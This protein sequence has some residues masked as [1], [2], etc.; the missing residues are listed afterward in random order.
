MTSM[1][2][3]VTVFVIALASSMMYFR[4]RSRKKLFG[5]REDANL[6][7]LRTLS[8]TNA[9]L[10]LFEE[11]FRTLAKEL[12]V[13]PGQLRTSDRLADIFEV[14]SWQLGGAQDALEELILKRTIDRPPT[15]DTIQDLLTWLANEQSNTPTECRTTQN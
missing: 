5:T 6:E 11:V 13:L 7:S 14:D 9:P 15:L 3:V 2:P 1:L 4:R 12:G 8:N 10:P